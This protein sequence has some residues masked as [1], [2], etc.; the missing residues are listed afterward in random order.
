VLLSLHTKSESCQWSI[1]FSSQNLYT[2][3]MFWIF[4]KIWYLHSHMVHQRFCLFGL[5]VQSN[6]KTWSFVLHKFK[7]ASGTNNSVQDDSIKEQL[8]CIFTGSLHTNKSNDG[9][10]LD[11]VSLINQITFMFG[12]WKPVFFGLILSPNLFFLVPTFVLFD[13]DNNL[14]KSTSLVE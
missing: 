4:G 14:N 8:C 10:S 3:N 12:F 7:Y 13:P 6:S 11:S 9:L 2:N 5:L 1:I